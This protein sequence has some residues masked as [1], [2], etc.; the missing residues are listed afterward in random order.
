MPSTK[1]K[2]FLSSDIIVEVSPERFEFRRDGVAK[3][4]KTKIYLSDDPKK[5]EVL[6]IGDDVTITKPNVCIELF[7]ENK[8]DVILNYSK[9]QCLEFFFKQAF[10]LILKKYVMIR[11]GVV[12]KNS[13]SLNK[14]LCG[15]QKFILYQAAVNSGA[16]ECFFED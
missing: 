6:G 12:F 8:E 16:R 2:K 15:Y 13:G 11:P 4:L 10:N 14:I 3:T 5:P 7:K 1:I 9:A